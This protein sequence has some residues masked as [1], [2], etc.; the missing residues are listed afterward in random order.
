MARCLA[1]DRLLPFAAA[2]RAIQCSKLRWK[3]ADASEKPLSL[4]EAFYMATAGGGRFFGNV[5][6]FEPGYEADAIVIDDADLKSIR[7]FTPAE[8]LERY[9]YLG[10]GRPKAKFVRGR[11]LLS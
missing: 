5:G 3:Y 6:L 9:T 4:S 10:S 8:R 11:R 7:P 2:C 1:R